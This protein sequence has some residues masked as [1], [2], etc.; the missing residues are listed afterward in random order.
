M[1]NR[2]RFIAALEGAYRDLFVN[3]PKYAYAASRTTPEALAVKMTDSLASGSANLD[4]EGIK[5]ACK[6]CG[7][8]QTY[9]ALR[10]F[11]NAS[12]E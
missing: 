5:R 3:D 1:T 10:S 2:E 9:K 12:N 11:L 7:V 8:K 4:G 6:A